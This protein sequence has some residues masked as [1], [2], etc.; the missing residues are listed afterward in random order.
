MRI[1]L[2]CPSNILY[3]PYVE[4]YIKILNEINIDYTIINW[5]RF[6][7]EDESEFSYRDS[8]VGHQRNFFDYL[9]YVRFVTNI[10]KKNNYD[11]IVIFGIQLVF[12]LRQYLIKNY[13][14]KYIIDIRDY[15][16]ILKFFSIES[17]I[18]NS[19]FTAISSPGYEEWLPISNN[20]V[21]N[22]NTKIETLD[23]MTI[24]GNNSINIKEISINYI[25]SLRDYDINESFIDSLKN[26]N[27]FNLNYYGEGIINKK[28]YNHIY[29]NEI[30]NVKI[31][32]Q[33]RREEEHKL[34][35]ES[36]FINALI[37]N[38]S[39]NSITLLPNRLYNAVIYGKPL[40]TFKGTYLSK[41]VEEYEL[42][43]V[44]SDFD[45]MDLK[46]IEYINNF[47]CDNFNLKRKLFIQKIIEDNM[48]FIN[49][50]KK[51]ICDS[52]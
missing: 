4:N 50:L 1:C 38:D 20:Y 33:Y 49:N 17:A 35:M 22:H 2:I 6:K 13:S 36:S 24:L 37:P 25:G 18:K 19:S 3:M 52:I 9:N 5:D 29:E 39:I 32:G 15:N 47:K 10:L 45:N 51:F 42:G 28:I 23:E 40:I 11:K 16:K 30:I 12:Y 14:N 44:L 48:N 7:I 34:Y 8:K 41:I 31:A 27:N 26:K 21:V 43:I 46:I